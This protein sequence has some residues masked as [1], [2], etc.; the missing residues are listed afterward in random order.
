MKYVLLIVFLLAIV[1]LP[2]SYA[3]ASEKI[4]S[5]LY[6]SDKDNVKV[7]ITFVDLPNVQKK[8]LFGILK[9]QITIKEAVK[10]KIRKQGK[11]KRELSLINGVSAEIPK[12]MLLELES[13]SNVLRVEEDKKVHAFLQQSG[14]LI[15]ANDSWN[16]QITGTNITGKGETVCVIDTGIDYTHPDLGGC[17][18]VTCKVVGGYDYVNNDSDP[19]DDENHGTHVAGIIAASG[20][21]MGVAPDA[22]LVALKA[23][24][25][26][27]SGYDSDVMAAIDWCV[28]NA[29]TYNISVISMSLG[30]DAQYTS[31]CD[32]LQS[33]MA[34]YINSAIANNISVVVA[35][36][37]DANDTG[38]SSPACIENS[39]RVGA[40]YDANI[41]SA[42]FSSCTDSSTAVDKITCYTNRGV[43]FTDMLLAPGGAIYSTII[44]NTYD[45]YHG[46]SMATPHVSGAYVLYLQA[47]RMLRDTVPRPNEIE[48]TFNDT[49]VLIYDAST[50]KNFSRIDALAAIESIKIPPKINYTYNNI[51]FDNSTNFSINETESVFFNVSSNQEANYSWYKNGTP[52]GTNNNYTLFTN[53]TDSGSMLVEARA[54]NLNGTAAV[55]WNV[56]ILDVPLNIV[57]FNPVT[58]VTVDE[59]ETSFFNVTTSRNTTINNWFVNGTL[60]NETMQKFN[61]SWTFDN[62]SV[63]EINYNGTDGIDNVS[64]VWSVKVSNINQAP[65]IFISNISQELQ[66]QTVVDL[67][68]NATDP[69]GDELIIT[70]NDINITVNGTML[71][72]N[73]TT[74]VTE[75]P[76]LIIVNDTNLT[77]NTTFYVNI[78]DTIAPNIT[79]ILPEN[80]TYGTTTITLNFSFDEEVA[81]CAYSVNGTANVTIGCGNAINLTVVEGNN[82]ITLFANDTLGNVGFKEVYFA[83]DIT[84][85]SILLNLTNHTID[86][87]FYI[88]ATISEPSDTCILEWM[89]ENETM[90]ISGNECYLNKTGIAP[91]NY[92]YKIYANDTVGNINSTTNQTIEVNYCTVGW[93]GWSS[94]ISGEEKRTYTY[95]NCST[96]VETQS[97]VSSS[98]KKTSITIYTP[99]TEIDVEENTSINTTEEHNTTEEPQI[100][101]SHEEKNITENIFE[102]L[103]EIEKK[104]DSAQITE[105]KRQELLALLNA[106]KDNVLLGDV[107]ST[108]T[109]MAQLE[110]KIENLK[111]E[112]SNEPNYF[113]VFGGIALLIILCLFY[114]FYRHKY[115]ISRMLYIYGVHEVHTDTVKLENYIRDCISKRFTE[116]RIKAKLLSVG[117][118]NYAIERALSEVYERKKTK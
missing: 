87:Y 54:I 68:L 81:W 41:G 58:D 20:T 43:N 55:A 10:E 24:D 39:T 73:Y 102:R 90:N 89:G 109:A 46:T 22:K 85:P 66:N 79:V 71:I 100:N 92:T 78:T 111:E 28:S 61:I 108:E 60:Q 33:A 16:K 103:K 19:M 77:A 104:I 31:Y 94:C 27:G 63:Y 29:S 83:V 82:N 67:L 13:D 114:Y 44:G 101:I 88:N 97:C 21:V 3:P 69:D 1:F 65:L 6:S 57:D 93:S 15:N 76:V 91:G 64:I 52:V 84:A 98:P 34:S 45:T 32:G 51:T 2:L 23:L 107:P 8:G 53:L 36:G 18:G 49:G 70:L 17:L 118:S 38:V 95:R 116:D 75:K 47:Y 11:L 30:G 110:L 37:N 48:Q 117:W 106:V 96:Y 80:K 72:F 59:N 7:I 5:A 12:S 4:D 105:D 40:T 115:L 9:N 113:W 42:P 50:T 86:D 99:I 25:S 74:T 56:T 35:T 62:S 26:T 112:N 14:P